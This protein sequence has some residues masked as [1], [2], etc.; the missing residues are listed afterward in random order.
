MRFEGRELTPWTAYV[1]ADELRVGD[2]YFVV[3]FH[4]KEMT[5]PSLSPVVFVGRDLEGG[6]KGELYFQDYESFR[7]GRKLSDPPS[8][9][10]GSRFPVGTVLKVSADDEAT[11][12]DFEQALE[13]LLRCSLR[14]AQR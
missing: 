8:A 11:V 3:S 5:I 14:R 12:H 4:D 13:S 2:L 1:P 7:D 10:K 9:A 6:D